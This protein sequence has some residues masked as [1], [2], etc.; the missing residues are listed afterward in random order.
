MFEIIIV[1]NG[2]K[3]IF[4]VCVVLCVRT[5]NQIVWICANESLSIYAI[6]NAQS[7]FW[8]YLPESIVFET[9]IVNNFSTKGV[10]TKNRIVLKKIYRLV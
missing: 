2:L 1:F 4:D 7:V 6:F 10:Q 5:K 3:I 8:T 9:L